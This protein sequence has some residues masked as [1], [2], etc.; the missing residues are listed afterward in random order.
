MKKKK[1]HLLEHVVSSVNKIGEQ[2]TI[3]ALIKAQGQTSTGTEDVI[4][5]FIISSTIDIFKISRKEL[6]NGL[7][8]NMRP[9]A[10]G[11]ACCVI[12]EHLKWSE[13]KMADH[14]KNF[15]PNI[16][17]YM[18]TIETLNSKIPGHPELILKYMTLKET[19]NSFID[20]NEQ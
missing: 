16:H 12:R 11:A 4:L 6:Y 18:K 13:P 2:E 1:S 3:K 8:R 15:S 19:V 9:R 14:F 10:I 17:N 20:K 7:S 5:E